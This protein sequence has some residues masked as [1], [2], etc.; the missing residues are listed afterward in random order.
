MWKEIIILI[1][2]ILVCYRT[3][4]HKIWKILLEKLDIKRFVILTLFFGVL[5]ILNGLAITQT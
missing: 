2:F 4:T 5:G 1:L 3:R